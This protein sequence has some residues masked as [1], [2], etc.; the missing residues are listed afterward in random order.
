MFRAISFPTSVLSSVL[1]GILVSGSG[2]AGNS[3]ETRTPIATAS[4]QLVPTV[5]KPDQAAA[6]DP[7]GERPIPAAASAFAPPVPQ[8][9][10]LPNGRKV[11]MLSKNELPLVTLTWVAPRGSANDGALPG[12][13]TLAARMRTEGAGKLDGAQFS[14]AID[15]LGASLSSV[16]YT[17]YSCLTLTVLK[18]NLQAAAKL[19][20]DAIFAPRNEE[21]DFVR[22]RTIL[23]DELRAESKD[24]R[25]TA[26]RVAAELLYGERK[27]G[28]PGYA[29]PK[30]GRTSTVAKISRANV[31]DAL[32]A[33]SL[34][35]QVVAVGDVSEAELRAL[36]TEVDSGK[37]GA[38]QTASGPEKKLRALKALPKSG[39]DV[40]L[41]ERPDSAQSVVALVLPGVSA[42]QPDVPP[43]AL[44][45][46][47]LG[48]SFTS[49]LNQDLREERGLSYGASSRIAALRNPGMIYAGASVFVDKTG[50][51]AKALLDDVSAFQKTGPTEE[52]VG[53]A[54]K[55]AQ[56]ETLEAY[57]S[58]AQIAG[59]LARLVG[60]GLPLDYEKVQAQKR[61]EVTLADVQKA[62][63]VYFQN[64]REANPRGFLL[65]VGPK[66]V[67]A[68][69]KAVGLTWQNR[70]PKP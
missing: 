3:G 12:L 42:N 5:A 53:R 13:A 38:L 47:V 1:L 27:F 18:K 54:K 28:S 19:W 8:S 58:T 16:T 62:A 45:N 44:A 29:H 23:L 68:Q 39:I 40:V 9:F 61:G 64:N 67:E 55:I 63:S 46:T 51:A 66:S 26:D 34:E 15:A 36:L 4:T 56:S 14:Q 48:G 17:D 7:L 24:P 41:V 20:A 57:A 37:P 50:E 6:L 43:L 70:S 52:E 21:A 33:F 32:A 35:G 49:R 65:V 11:L 59:R 25:A 10:A 69:L 22:A 30:G 2:C 31:A 60:L